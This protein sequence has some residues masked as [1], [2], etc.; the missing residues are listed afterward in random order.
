[1]YYKFFVE[2]EACLDLKTFRSPPPNITSS[3][4]SVRIVFLVSICRLLVEQAVS[5][6]F[7]LLHQCVMAE[8]RKS[9]SVAFQSTVLKTLEKMC[10]VF[11]LEKVLELITIELDCALDHVKFHTDK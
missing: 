11:F 2:Q 4:Q 5:Y 1:M 3:P 6:E 8:K 10:Q 9:F 7:V